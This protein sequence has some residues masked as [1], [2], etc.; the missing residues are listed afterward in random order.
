MK[1]I[2]GVPL[3]ESCG[4]D[5]LAV[6]GLCLELQDFRPLAAERRHRP[7]QSLGQASFFRPRGIRA[8]NH[9]GSRD[10]PGEG[11]CEGLKIGVKKSSH[12]PAPPPPVGRPSRGG[13]ETQNS[14]S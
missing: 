4:A 10:P 14:E 11:G 6:L 9:Q 3:Q 5:L 1:P 12:L 2:P 13:Q 7:S 8:D